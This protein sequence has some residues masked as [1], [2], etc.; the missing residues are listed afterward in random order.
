MKREHNRSSE[1]LARHLKVTLVL[2]R[3]IKRYRKCSRGLV[4]NSY[5][6]SDIVAL[7]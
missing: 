1:Q 2:V 7:T 5:D 4:L 6:K 3:K